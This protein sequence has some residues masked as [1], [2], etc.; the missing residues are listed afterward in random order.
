M[1]IL[2]PRPGADDAWQTLR[3]LV[4]ALPL[5][6]LVEG[7]LLGVLLLMHG[8]AR[9]KS[10]R[11]ASKAVSLRPMSSATWAKN[12][13]RASST[14]T[15][16]REVDLHPKGQ[17]VD[18]APGNNRVPEEAKYLAES[19]NRVKEETRAKE[20]SQQWS[21]A[22]PKS[23]ANPTALPSAKGQPA[24]AQE[25]P[26]SSGFLSSVFG[27]QR[28]S[29]LGE[30]PSPGPS[31]SVTSSD[32]PS[33]R[34]TEQGTQAGGGDATEGGGAPND[35]LKG[36][37]EGEGTF[38]NTREWRYASFFN[39]V[40]QAVSARWDPNGRLRAMRRELGLVERQTLL[41]VT[42]RPDGSLVEAAVAQSS[43]IEALDLEAIQAFEKAQPFANPPAALVEHGAIRFAFGFT[44]TQGEMSGL[45]PG[46]MRFSR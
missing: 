21:R 18:V 37:K 13:G 45:T 26:A 12:R 33:P 46:F 23:A 10:A 36:V 8:P 16:E 31:E 40:K 25:K 15:P 27:L 5:A 32:E 43:G 9:E 7:A 3:R 30:Q 20:Q 34:G 2:Q 19:N 22:T 4:Y 28:L 35:D 11:A 14:P 29:L 38:L 6:L 44:I 1:A 39:R 41:H 17:V 24:P 42:L